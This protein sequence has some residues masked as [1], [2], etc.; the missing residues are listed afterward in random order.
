MPV[1]DVREPDVDLERPAQ[2][3]S[4]G[5]LILGMPLPF[6]CSWKE[7]GHISRVNHNHIFITGSG[8]DQRE[9]S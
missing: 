1:N 4:L 6:L 8:W 7:I 9:Q 3:T 5:P 2:R